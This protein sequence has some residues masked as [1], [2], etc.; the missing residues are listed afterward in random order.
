MKHPRVIIHLFIS[1][2]QEPWY[3]ATEFLP[4][5]NVAKFLETHK[6]E[7]R[8]NLVEVQENGRTNNNQ[9]QKKEYQNNTNEK[10]NSIFGIGVLL[11][12]ARQVAEA[13]EYL[14]SQNILHRYI[15]ACNVFLSAKLNAKLSSSILNIFLQLYFMYNIFSIPL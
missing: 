11:Q 4:Q 6:N 3:L 13:M 12:W 9:D 10:S 5:G 1:S 7:F 2:S 15:A 8:N 14:V